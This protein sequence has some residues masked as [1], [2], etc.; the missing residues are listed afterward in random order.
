MYFP[1]GIVRIIGLK[2]QTMDTTYDTL[3]VAN[4]VREMLVKL[5]NDEKEYKNLDEDCKIFIDKYN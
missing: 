5:T 3:R 4:M 1:I 2:C